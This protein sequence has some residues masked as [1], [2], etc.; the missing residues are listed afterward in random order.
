MSIRERID[1]SK[2]DRTRTEEYVKFE[3]IITD[4]SK[5]GMKGAGMIQINKHVFVAG[6]QVFGYNFASA[7]EEERTRTMV[8]SVG[9]F[10][11]VKEPIQLRQNVKAVDMSDNIQTHQEILDKLTVELVLLKEDYKY[12]SELGEDY[13]DDLEQLKPINEKLKSITL[14]MEAKT[15]MKKEAAMLISYL[16][17]MS[18]AN[19]QSKREN[20]IMFSYIFNPNEHSVELTEEEIKIEA[21]KALSSKAKIYGESM[22]ACGCTYKRLSGLEL[23][24]LI[25]HHNRP[26]TADEIKLV[27]LLGGA[28]NSLFVTSD[29]LLEMQ[30]EKI[31]E[32][33]YR[34]IRERI[35]L[36]EEER[37]QSIIMESQRYMNRIMEETE[38]EAKKRMAVKSAS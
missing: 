20:Q 29:S 38:K 3:D 2:F 30:M 12:Y 10:R 28:T 16:E 33:K 25:R 27:D 5:K 15:A 21:M 31:G 19:N 37:V 8:G 32:E 34:E 7:S 24:D 35:A 22:E 18:A 4:D 36:E 11:N 13:I 6:I 14:E 9:F 26:R 23:L 1:H 17:N